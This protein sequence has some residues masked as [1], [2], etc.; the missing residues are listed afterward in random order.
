MC[1]CSSVDGHMGDALVGAVVNRVPYTFVHTAKCAQASLPSPGEGLRLC[2]N[3]GLVLGC[4]SLVE[5]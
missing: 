1:N 4:C 5:Y 2:L 3:R